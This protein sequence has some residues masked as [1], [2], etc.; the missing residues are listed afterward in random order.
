MPAASS[1]NTRSSSPLTTRKSAGLSRSSCIVW[2][3]LFP[4]FFYA[5]DIRHFFS[6]PYTGS[7]F[8]V[9]ACAP[10]NVVQYDGLLAMRA[11]AFYNLKKPFLRWFCCNKAALKTAAALSS[12]SCSRSLITA[13][14]LL[15]QCLP[16]RAPAVYL[17]KV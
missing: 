9:S 2:G 10:R 14:V 11:I 17:S 5:A 7:S 6:K 3:T 16:Q 15:P 1:G 12:G 4:R 8:H 13:R